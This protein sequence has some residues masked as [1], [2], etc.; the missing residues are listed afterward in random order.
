VAA[1]DQSQGSEISALFLSC[2]DDFFGCLPIS[3]QLA[4]PSVHPSIQ[5]IHPTN[6]FIIM[7]KSAT[8]V[9]KIK[10]GSEKD[11]RGG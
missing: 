6:P 10:S 5:P 4:N 3:S 9:K 11:S 2:Y 8:K 1:K 7:R